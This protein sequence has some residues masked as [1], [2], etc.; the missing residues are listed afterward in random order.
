MT[1]FQSTLFIVFAVVA[2]MI[3]VDKN[4]GDYL[5]LLLKIIKV[6]IERFY[7]MIRFH[8]KNP[9]TNLIMKWKYDKLAKELQKEFDDSL[10]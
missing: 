9:I 2:Y 5:I 4:V 8:P 10:R 7:W 6:N 3:I 1:P